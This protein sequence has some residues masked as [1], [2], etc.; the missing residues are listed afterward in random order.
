MTRDE[1]RKLIAAYATGSL[2]D[3]ERTALFEVALEDQE[4]FEELAGEQVLKEI[5]DEPGARQRLL[6]ALEPPRHRA[7]LW[8]MAAATVAIVV[9]V[10]VSYR[11][12]APP[13][14][15]AQVTKSAEPV[16][17]P[18]TPETP[19]TPIQPPPPPARV[20]RKVPPPPAPAPKPPAQ[21]RAQLADKLEA[22]A[23]ARGGAVAGFAGARQAAAPLAE[24][25]VAR[26]AGGFGFN[27]AVRADG[28]LQIVPLAA[29]FLAVTT[30]INGNDAVVFPSGAVSAG[31]LLRIP[32]PSEATSLVIRFSGM[33]GITG[34]PVRRDEPS[35]T[36]TDQD[37]PNARII[38]QLFLSRATQ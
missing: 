37:P 4:L 9:G 38:I 11:T 1:A 23:S 16:G 21:E 31:M 30:S 2:T 32:I 25:L 33:E 14:Q 6:A 18:A 7:W 8:A 10:V 5:L 15:I 3:A 19:G 27:Y 22:E 35:G 26:V 17:S 20:A 12:S 13:Q 36:V 24:N 34:S 29:G 28:F